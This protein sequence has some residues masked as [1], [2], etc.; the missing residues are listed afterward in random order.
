MQTPIPS[1]NASPM[2]STPLSPLGNI[3]FDKRRINK[4]MLNPID[5]KSL[6]V[7]INQEF[8]DS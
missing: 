2:G 4:K 5:P 3:R 8:I 1:H 6:K 7:T